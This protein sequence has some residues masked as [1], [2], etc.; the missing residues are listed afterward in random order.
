MASSFG[1]KTSHINI[2]MSKLENRYFPDI[3]LGFIFSAPFSSVNNKV[4][5]VVPSVNLYSVSLFT[6][7][8]VRLILKTVHGLL[9][10][11]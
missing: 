11:C 7:S 5:A 6:D 1:F 2:F 4:L 9:T 3:S 10:Q 8:C